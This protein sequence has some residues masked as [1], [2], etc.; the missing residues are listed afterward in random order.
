MH[1]GLLAAVVILAAACALNLALV[2]RLSKIVREQPAAAPT[3]DPG[4]PAVGFELPSFAGL[5]SRGLPLS[6]ADLATGTVV[7][8]FLSTTCGPCRESLPRFGTFAAELREAGG[9]AVAVVSGPAE[10]GAAD[11]VG[12]LSASCDTIETAGYED[13]RFTAFGVSAYPTFLQFTDGRLT[14]ATHSVS[15]LPVPVAA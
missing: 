10:S 14:V 7:L 8:A 5:T 3:V 6:S 15:A 2:L 9:R 13:P 12:A 4:L 11:M 1:T